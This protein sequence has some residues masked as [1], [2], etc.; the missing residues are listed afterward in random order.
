MRKI[1]LLACLVVILFA[2]GCASET[3]TATP[4]TKSTVTPV[5]KPTQTVATVLPTKLPLST[6]VPSSTSI[7][8]AT[9]SIVTWTPLPTVALP[10]V[11]PG[12]FMSNLR[13]DPNPPT[14]GTDLVFSATFVNTTGAIQ[15]VKW[16]VYIYRPDNS[17]NPF[18]QTTALLTGIPTGTNEFK[19]AG[20]W[21]IGLGGPCENYIARTA[22]LDQNNQRVN[23]TR[24]DGTP[25][26]KPFTVCAPSD[27]PSATPGPSPVPTATPTFAPGLFV[28]DLHTDPDPPTRGSDLGFI[29]TFVNTTGSPANVKWIV[30]IYRPGERNSTGETTATTSNLGNGINDYR[31]NGFWKLPLGGPCE[32][33]VARV[34]WF[35][36]GN[37]ARMFTTFDN[38]TFE[39]PLIICPP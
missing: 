7:P 10:T 3:P 15:N 36:S 4:S 5:P 27:L 33:F 17:S 35:D 34:A 38:Q 28:I 18:G 24:P 30:Y 37:Q 21:K 32:S 12:L 8:T 29:P 25:F 26:E 14:R 23:F 39:K 2:A 16:L 1:G 19:G 31:S 22:W 9:L 20:S 11:N 6:V 13:I